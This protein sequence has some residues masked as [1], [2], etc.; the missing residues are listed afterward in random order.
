MSE[1]IVECIANY[2]DARRP[3][4]IEK[5]AHS[6]LSVSGITLLDRHSDQDHNRTVLTFVGPPEQVGEAAFR[7]IAKAAELIDLDHHTGEH[8]R[9]GAADV[10]PFVPIRNISMPECVLMA[11]QLG[12]RVGS[13]LNIPVY[14]YEEAAARPER[15]NLENIRRGQYEALKAEIGLNPERDPDFG[16][17][18]VSP[19]GAVVIGARQPLIAFNIYLTTN[20]VSIAKKI[21]KAVRHSSGGLRYVKAL[22]LLGRRPR[23]GLDEPDKFSRYPNR[24]RC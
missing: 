11:R 1:P 15:K 22:G 13:E 7:S 2:S 12:A 16:P 5:I 3:E 8:P 17:K 24:P 10:V 6:I 19:A 21:A 23:P 9:I 14:L 4:V 18:K 20:D